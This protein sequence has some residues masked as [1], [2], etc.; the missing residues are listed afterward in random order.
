MNSHKETPEIELTINKDKNDTS[1]QLRIL[2]IQN[3]YI[4]RGGGQPVHFS[5]IQEAAESIKHSVVNTFKMK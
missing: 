5:N 3:G 1:V 2:Q 4:V